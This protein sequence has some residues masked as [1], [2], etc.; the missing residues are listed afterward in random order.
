MDALYDDPAL[1]QFYDWD[2]PWPEAFDWFAGLVADASTVLDL[3]AG[4]AFFQQPLPG[5]GRRWLASIRRGPCWTSRDSGTV[6]GACNGF[7][8]ASQ[9]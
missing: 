7:F 1:A 2:N 8:R 4:R 3:G 6:A 9:G 5:G